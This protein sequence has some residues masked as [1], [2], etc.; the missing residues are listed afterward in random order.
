M[1][2]VRQVKPIKKVRKVV[3]PVRQIKEEPR[4]WWEPTTADKVPP[5]HPLTLCAWV[6]PDK[7]DKLAAVDGICDHEPCPCKAAI[8]YAIK[9]STNIY[10]SEEE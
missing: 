4:E 7:R 10:T 6:P 8:K 9:H 3:K 1:A 5:Y 2:K